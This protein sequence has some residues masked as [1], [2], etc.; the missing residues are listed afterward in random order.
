MTRPPPPPCLSAEIN[1]GIAWPEIALA[2]WC[3][4]MALLVVLIL[5]YFPEDVA[6]AKHEGYQPC[7]DGPQGPPPTT[8]SGVQ[9]PRKSH[10]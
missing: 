2:V 6:P 10:D 7:G 5:M 8:G 1:A 4:A 9:A 3:F